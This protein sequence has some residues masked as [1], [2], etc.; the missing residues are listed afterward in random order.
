MLLNLRYVTLEDQQMIL[1]LYEQGFSC[2][3]IK[4][5]LNVSITIRSIE[6]FVKKNG[7]MRSI[8]DAYRNAI[9]RGRVVFV[10]KETKIHRTKLP[11][12]MRYKIL[13]RDNFR[14]SACGAT[15]K[16]RLLEVDHINDIPDDNR[17][18]NLQILCEECNLGKSKI[19]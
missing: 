1:F 7:L 11:L 5:L 18:E 10:K 4:E 14:C 13:E 9:Q 6:R 16:E 17:E 12:G 2:G 8:G 3:E 15:S 19:L